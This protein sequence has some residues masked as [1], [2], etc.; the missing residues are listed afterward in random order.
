MILQVRIRLYVL[1]VRDFPDPYNPMTGW[2]GMFQPS[3]LPETSGRVGGFLG[4]GY[5]WMSRWKLGSK[6]RISGLFHPNIPRLQVGE[7]TNPL[8]PSPL[9]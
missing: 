7:I 8:I 6:V 5:G 1:R 4:T 2:D 3:I 9:I